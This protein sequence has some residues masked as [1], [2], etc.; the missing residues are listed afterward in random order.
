MYNLM[1]G[2]V[3][4]EKGT[5]PE[6]IS[7]VVQIIQEEQIPYGTLDIRNSEKD[8]IPAVIVYDKLGI[9]FYMLNE[10]GSLDWWQKLNEVPKTL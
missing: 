6:L 3:C 1:H 8:I 9:F 7:Q 4:L 10:D 2:Q 5:I